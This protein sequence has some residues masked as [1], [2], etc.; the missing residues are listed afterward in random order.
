MENL[1][2]R[3]LETKHC[4]TFTGRVSLS[5]PLEVEKPRGMS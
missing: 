5:D 1:L 4:L 3:D 2:A